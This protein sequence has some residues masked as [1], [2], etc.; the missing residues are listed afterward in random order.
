MQS[1]IKSILYDSADVKKKVAENL[2]GKIEEI[3]LAIIKSIRQGGKVVLFGNGGSAA[4]AQHIQGELTH[5]LDIKNRKAIP[6]IALNTNSSVLT[7]IGN[8]W[9]YD[10]VF[11][12]QIEAFVQ[13]NDV[14]IAFSTSGNSINI[15]KGLIQAKKEG[16]TTVAFTGKNGGKIK[17]LAD[18]SFIVPSDSTQRIQE[19]HITVGHIICKLVEDE[20]YSVS[21]E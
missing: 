20:L 10:R 6:S 11:E 1:I 13:H 14:V 16:A 17:D 19:A 3:A 18:I 4:D 15:I 8:D 9:G 5:Q 2:S 12:R 7:A 21:R